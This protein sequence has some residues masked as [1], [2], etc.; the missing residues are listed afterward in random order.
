MSALFAQFSHLIIVCLIF[1]S[2]PFVDVVNT[3]NYI[4]VTWEKDPMSFIDSECTCTAAEQLT[5]IILDVA[6]RHIPVTAVRERPSTHPWLSD[7]CVHAVARKQAA[8]GTADYQAE[9][10]RCSDVFRHE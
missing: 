6:R 5:A 10:R 1:H 4:S 3:V 9:V 2:V 8:Y 7:R